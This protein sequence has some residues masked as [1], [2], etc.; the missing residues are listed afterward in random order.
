MKPTAIATAALVTIL[1]L[2]VSADTFILKDGSK[3]EG[4][5]VSPPRTEPFQGSAQ[6]ARAAE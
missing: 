6:L 4:K 3:L 1:A 5:I 2:P